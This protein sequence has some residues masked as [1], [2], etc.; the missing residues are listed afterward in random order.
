MSKKYLEAN[1]THKEYGLAMTLAKNGYTVIR[2]AT[3]KDVDV[4]AEPVSE[5]SHIILYRSDEDFLIDSQNTLKAITEEKRGSFRACL[6][7]IYRS[8]PF[9]VKSM[10]DVLQGCVPLG[11]S[12]EEQN[13]PTDAPQGQKPEFHRVNTSDEKTPIPNWTSWLGRIKEIPVLSE[14]LLFDRITRFWNTKSELLVEGRVVQIKGTVST[15]APVVVGPPM[16]KR[17]AHLNFRT[18]AGAVNES[19]LNTLLT[20]SAGQ[21]V[22]ALSLPAEKDPEGSGL[23][24]HARIKEGQVRYL[25][26]YQGIVRNSIPLYVDSQYFINTVA[27]MFA[28]TTKSK[29]FEATVTGRIVR[30]PEYASALSRMERWA[31]GWESDRRIPLWQEGMPVYGIVIGMDESTS[32]EKV[33]EANYLDGDIWVAVEKDG[34][35]SM[36]SRFGDLSNEKDVQKMI[37]QMREEIGVDTQVIFQFDQID[38]PFGEVGYSEIDFAQPFLG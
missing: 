9:A 18:S 15:Y 37:G 31:A 24:D 5:R 12:D 23:S 20:F 36:V 8:S 16:L 25:G 21:M 38:K 22:W 1:I 3:A 30:L 10:I 17:D 34:K 7:D 14:P 26:L 27:P 35:E 29:A 28:D 6:H 33:G 4:E 32:I 19:S 13:L 2:I 11:G